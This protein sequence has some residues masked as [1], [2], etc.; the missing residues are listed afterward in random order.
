M[1]KVAKL[2]L[3]SVEFLTPKV[4]ELP[5]FKGVFVLKRKWLVSV[6]HLVNYIRRGW[7]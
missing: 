4:A 3:F 6:L 5:L 7:E 1:V 2:S